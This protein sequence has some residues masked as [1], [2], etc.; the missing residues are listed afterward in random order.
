M[1]TKMRD[2]ICGQD[3]NN[4]ISKRFWGYVKSFSNSYRI[5]ET[6]S[7]DS[8]VSSDT[9]VKVNLFNKYFYSQFS[10]ESNYDIDINFLHDSDFN[11]SFLT[12]RIQNHLQNLNF[13]KACGPDQIPGIVLRRCSDTLAEPSLIIFSLQYGNSTGRLETG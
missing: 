4:A 9:S 2:N 13:N 5:P 6:L 1:K 12:S 11:I 7:F 8:T 3:D 10:N